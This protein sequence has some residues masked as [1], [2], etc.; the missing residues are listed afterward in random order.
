MSL[1]RVIDPL[2]P[3]KAWLKGAVGEAAGMG[4]QVQ[5]GPAGNV[6]VLIAELLFPTLQVFPVM[7]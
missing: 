4:V 5:V 2:L 1:N 7:P 3:V 6:F